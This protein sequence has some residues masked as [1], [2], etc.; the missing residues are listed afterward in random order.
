MFIIGYLYI[1]TT[2]SMWA[3]PNLALFS[4]SLISCFLG[5]LLRYFLNDFE[6]VPLAPVIAGMTFLYRFHMH[7]VSVVRSSHSR[8]FSA[9]FLITF[10][11][12]GI[13]TLTCMFLFH[14]HGLWC[15]VYCWNSSGYYYYY[16]YYYYIIVSFM[17]GSH[18]HIPGTN[19][20]PRGTHCCSY[21]V[22]VVYGA[23]MSSSCVGSVV[24]LH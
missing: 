13:A 24:L 19:H 21:S 5:V 6:E 1:I 11:S 23:S 18:T 4:S 7:C 14:H 15:P 22:F 20:I 9:S 10:L 3:V 8:T 16:Y 17:Q 12:P 2:R